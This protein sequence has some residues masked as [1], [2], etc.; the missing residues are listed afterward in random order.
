[1]EQVLQR[2]EELAEYMQM[3]ARV[4]NMNIPGVSLSPVAAAAA[5][6]TVTASLSASS[7]SSTSATTLQPSS[8]FQSQQ[9][10]QKHQTQL[11][12]QERSPQGDEQDQKKPAATPSPAVARLSNEAGLESSANS[13]ITSVPFAC[14]AIQLPSGSQMHERGSSTTPPTL[15]QMASTGRTA[16]IAPTLTPTIEIL[17]TSKTR[18][19]LNAAT[20]AQANKPAKRTYMGGRKPKVKVK[21]ADEASKLAVTYLDVLRKAGKGSVILPCRARGLPRTHNAKVRAV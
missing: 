21:A 7:S 13:T 9:Q 15:A 16:A 8:T 11:P 4:F 3:M 18:K 12:I 2:Q 10:Q 1:M 17:A 14:A 6:A 20:S 19:S 5:A